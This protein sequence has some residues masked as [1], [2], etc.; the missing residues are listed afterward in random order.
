MNGLDSDI[1]KGYM[2]MADVV[3]DP[4]QQRTDGTFG[5]EPELISEI[6]ARLIKGF[7]GE[8]L[9][10]DSIALTI[11]HFPGGG[12]RENGFDPHYK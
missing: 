4:E 1:R 6:I 10:E 3:T 7:Q 8:E 12:A 9:N 5:E 11:K 2:Y